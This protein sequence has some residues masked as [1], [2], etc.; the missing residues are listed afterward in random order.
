M[1][2]EGD[3]HLL[4]ALD[5]LTI[6]TYDCFICTYIRQPFGIIKVDFRKAFDGATAI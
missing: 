2:P 6:N 5:N 1:M 3:P 4:Q